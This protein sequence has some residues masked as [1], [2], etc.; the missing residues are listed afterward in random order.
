MTPADERR[1]GSGSGLDE[2]VVGEARHAMPERVE[3]A[4]KIQSLTPPST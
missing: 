4:L 3:A 1:Q 2:L